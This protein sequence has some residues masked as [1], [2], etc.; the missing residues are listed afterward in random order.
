M[1]SSEST[2]APES[3]Q[4]P[5]R[6][7]PSL[8][9]HRNLAYSI[10]KKLGDDAVKD[11][12]FTELGKCPQC[13]KDILSP[14][15][16]AFTTLP[17]GHVFHRE[18][19]ENKFLLTCQNN[20]PVADCNATVKPVVS[21]RRFSVTSVLSEHPS[22]SQST[23]ASLVRRMSNQLQVDSPVIQEDPMEGVQD[24]LIQ[25]TET[26]LTCA[27][28]SEEITL[29]FSKDT[30]F[31]S[32]KHAVHFDCIDDPRKKCPT[33]PSADD[34]ETIPIRNPISVEQTSSTTQKKRSRESGVSTENSSSK[35]AKK[36]GGKKVSS[37]LKKLIE[38][39]LTDVPVPT[40]GENLEE[41][42][43]SATSI[44]LQLSDKIDNAETKNESAFRDLIFSYFDFGE[45]VF[46]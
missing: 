15:F 22:G 39:L 5:E 6:S 41:A 20:C 27:K 23:A 10:L 19:V 34:L 24:T 11:A 33:C 12:E 16:E 8:V 4:V 14:P 29:D 3:F 9:N 37:M 17:C 18:C 38:E 26:R 35:K 43:E 2:K 30:V 1:S 32:C 46:K 28:C 31:L 36:T 45:A 13:D 25:E 7:S 42:N 40:A 44:F 21:E